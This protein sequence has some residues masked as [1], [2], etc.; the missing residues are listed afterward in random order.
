[1]HEQWTQLWLCFHVTWEGTW[2]TPSHMWE[3]KQLLLLLPLSLPS[4]SHSIMFLLL[5]AKQAVF[6]NCC[7]VILGFFYR[8][9]WLMF[10]CE[11]YAK[12]QHQ[13]LKMLPVP[14][15]FDHAVHYTPV[16]DSTVMCCALPQSPRLLSCA[17][18]M[19]CWECSRFILRKNIPYVFLFD[20]EVR[21]H[22]VNGGEKGLTFL[23]SLRVN[24]ILGLALAPMC[25]KTNHLM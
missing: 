12:V 7:C 16:F 17:G 5:G 13:T 1:M 9:Q 24:S 15:W 25:F 8:V 2:H 14:H 18:W 19:M 3:A 6:G 23:M 11:K 22:A 21:T 10:L 20:A 4:S